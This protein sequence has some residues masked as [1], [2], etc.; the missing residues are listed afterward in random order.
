MLFLIVCSLKS[1]FKPIDVVQNENRYA[2]KYDKL[3]LNS[4]FNGEMQD[5]FE[6]T[7][8]DQIPL[9][10]KFK[11]ANNLFDSILMKNTLNLIINNDV[12]NYYSLGSIYLFGK[13]NLVYMPYE[14]SSYK[15]ELK[16]RVK[17]L[18]KTMDLYPNIDYYF[19]YIEKDTDINFV[20]G[21]KALVYEYIKDRLNSKNISNF[22]INNFN[23]FKDLF[24]K[25]DH[26]WNYKGSYKGYLEVLQ[27]LKLKNPKEPTDERCFKGEFVGSKGQALANVYNEKFCAYTF[28]FDDIDVYINGKIAD[29]YGNYKKALN[30][31]YTNLSYDGFYGYDE[32]E[33]IFDNNDSNK[34]NIL[35]IGESFDNAIIK[36]LAEKFNKTIAIDLRNYKHYMNKE[37]N[38]EEYIE[39]YEIDKVLF[40]GNINY[41]ISQE[42][43][44][45]K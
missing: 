20:N 32:G 42:F 1:I 17:S 9:S 5:N 14:L 25:T 7:L 3:N 19:Y 28:D 11:T 2:N 35:I 29:D 43:N 16:S 10:S 12:Y 31:E 22:E 27:L 36:L 4:Y 39:K 37:F 18:N 33:I 34:E 45:I 6:K 8:S 13:E 40:I 30:G 15:E 41:Y 44:V 38:Y 21:K 24:Y 26:H 23:D